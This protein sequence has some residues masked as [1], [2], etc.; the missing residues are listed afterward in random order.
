MENFSKDRTLEM[1]YQGLKSLLGMFLVS[2]HED[3]VLYIS[4]TWD[5]KNAPACLLNNR[6]N[7]PERS[8]Y[9]MLGSLWGNRHQNRNDDRGCHVP[10]KAV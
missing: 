9:L 4:I 6:M 5:S 7:A 2:Q 10:F 3:S 8:N 1:S